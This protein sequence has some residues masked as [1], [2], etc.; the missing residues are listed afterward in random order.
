MRVSQYGVTES[1]GLYYRKKHSE[2]T[3]LILNNVILY[4]YRKKSI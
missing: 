3:K 1:S 4:E 2:N